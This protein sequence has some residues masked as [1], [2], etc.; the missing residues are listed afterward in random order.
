MNPC[1]RQ[2]LQ[3]AVIVLS[4]G[5]TVANCSG[6]AIYTDAMKAVRI[7]KLHAL[8]WDG[9]NTTVGIHETR[10][11][12]GTESGNCDTH[13]IKDESQSGSNE[14]VTKATNDSRHKIESKVGKGMHFPFDN[15]SKNEQKIH[16]KKKMEEIS[17][18]EGTRH[19]CDEILTYKDFSGN[20]S[21][22]CG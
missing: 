10:L 12:G 18:K 9:D 17:M 3:A 19:Q 5:A 1:Q 15:G 11:T 6:A 2:F 13:W 21:K 14:D 8:G 4:F 20:H 16:V 22:E 7:D